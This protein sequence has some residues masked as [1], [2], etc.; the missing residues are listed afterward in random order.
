MERTAFH[1]YIRLVIMEKI[2]GRKW[3]EKEEQ[4]LIENWG[5]VSITSIA[6]RLGRTKHAVTIHKNRMGLGAFLDSGDYITWNQFIQ[7]LGLSY[8]TYRLKSWVENKN[9]PLRQK[10]VDKNVFK[11]VYL[12]EW[13]DWAYENQSFLD[14]SKFEENILGEEPEWAKEKRKK[15]F[16]KS[17]KFTSDPWTKQEDEHLKY[18]VAAHKYTV[19]EISKM[20][21]RTC[22]A[23]QRRLVDLNIKD[24]PLKADN[25]TLWTDEQLYQL[26]ELIKSGYDYELIAEILGKSSKACRGRVYS[27]YLTENLDKARK[28]MGNG[29]FGA[30]RPI[31][32]LKQYN[33]MNTEERIETKDAATRL[34]AVLHAEL[35]RQL[36]ETDWGDFFQ[37]DMCENYSAECL[38]GEGC[39]LCRNFKRIRS[40]GCKMCGKT[41][42]E[43]QENTYCAVCRDMRKKQWLRKRFVLD[44]RRIG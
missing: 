39:D 11:V 13:W 15:D 33:L 25:H 36:S 44:K 26:G 28:L 32:S 12:D 43:K 35:K 4:Y 24:R 20:T 3:T 10:R 18:L 6:K 27:M 40:Q 1:T 38:S 9:F 8:G 2:M 23:I 19:D 17:C 14:F 22:G 42:W 30:N 5:T 21:K 7:A 37:K 16:E 31:R 41:F 29:H 34:A